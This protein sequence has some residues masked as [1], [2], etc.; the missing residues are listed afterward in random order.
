MDAAVA[1]GATKCR[2]LRTGTIQVKWQ[3]ARLSVHGSIN[4]TPVPMIVDTGAA[5][6]LIPYSLV[7]P[8]GL[9]V[10]EAVKG[11][12]YGG[13]GV[14]RVDAVRTF[15]M[16][17][18]DDVLFE[19]DLEI[20]DHEIAFP[21]TSGLRRVVERLRRSPFV[22]AHVVVNEPDALVFV[23]HLHLERDRPRERR[24]QIGLGVRPRT[25]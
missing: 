1:I 23:G 4:G 24:L 6:V 13:G 8:L 14:S 21:V 2:Y 22:I 16:S 7:D 12:G 20:N 5:S 18:G 19:H 9:P 3:G 15:R 25:S 17:I 10:I 11:E